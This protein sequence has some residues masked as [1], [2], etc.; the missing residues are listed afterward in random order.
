VIPT[1]I[2]EKIKS[3]L[4]FVGFLC[5]LAIIAGVVLY[6]HYKHRKP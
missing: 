5:G 1:E 3:E 4:S 6:E 2:K